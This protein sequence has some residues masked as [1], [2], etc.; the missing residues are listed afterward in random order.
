MKRLY[1]K[2]CSEKNCLLSQVKTHKYVLK[3]INS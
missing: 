1:K 2:K 3:P